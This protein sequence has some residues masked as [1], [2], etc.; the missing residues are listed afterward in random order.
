AILRHSNGHAI[1]A[2]RSQ[3]Q[4]LDSGLLAVSAGVGGVPAVA[5]VSATVV[6]DVRLAQASVLARLRGAGAI[7]NLVYLTVAVFIDVSLTR[8]GAG[9]LT[10]A[11]GWPSPCFAA[12]KLDGCAYPKRQVDFGTGRGL[13][14]DAF[15]VFVGHAVAVVVVAF[16]RARVHGGNVRT[17]A[18]L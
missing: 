18:R 3:R 17:R 7:G 2:S 11:G 13:P 1:R 14:C 16:D 8:L 9:R 6:G 5:R 10:R 12:L 4:H 15:A